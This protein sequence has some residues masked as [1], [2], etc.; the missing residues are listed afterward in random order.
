MI[1]LIQ[2]HITEISNSKKTIIFTINISNSNSKNLS[3]VN[4]N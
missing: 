4:R 3:N 1:N 2:R